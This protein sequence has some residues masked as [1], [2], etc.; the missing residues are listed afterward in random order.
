M[1]LL[2]KDITIINFD[3]T[4]YAQRKLQDFSHEKLNFQQMK[5]VNLYCEEDS[6]QTL[7][8]HLQKRRNRGITFIGNGNYHYLTY[9]LLTEITKAFTLVL[10]DNHS[11]LGTD[12]D[13]ESSMLSCGSWVSYALKK[14]PLLQRVVIIGPTTMTLAHYANNPR[15]VIF[16]FN[17]SKPY[18]LKAILS[19][20]QTQSVYI[21]IDKDV[22]N[23]NEVTT[24]WDQGKMDTSRLIYCLEMILISKQVEGI[25]ICGEASFSPLDALLPN[26]QSIIHKNERANIQILQKCIEVSSI[27]TRGA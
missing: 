23:P 19:A 26:Y 2:K 14:I 3:E 13:Q 1:G 15:V 22:L 4:Y 25:D 5:H 21:S 12:I 9:P 17:R 18:S 10:F 16:P 7:K 11:D 8:G 6:L 20:I 24:N 27:E